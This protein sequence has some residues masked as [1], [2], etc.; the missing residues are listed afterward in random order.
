MTDAA[1]LNA[2][3]NRI[4]AN[5]PQAV[6]RLQALLRIPSISNDPA[7]APNCRAAADWLVRE[8]QDLGFDAQTYDTPGH[9]MVVGQAG[10]DQ[11]PCLLFYGHYDVQPVDPLALWHN[12]PFDPHIEETPDGAVIRGRGASD[13]K[14]QLMTFLEACRAFQAETGTLPARIKVFFEGEEESGSPSLV[15]FMATHADLLSADLALICDT[16]LFQG[17]TPAI[18]TMLRGLLGE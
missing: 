14:G 2:V 3:L 16:G 12:D 7:F 17:K 1:T 18:V 9:P 13:D 4:D 8:L 10:A 11:G 6:T 15:P 5:M